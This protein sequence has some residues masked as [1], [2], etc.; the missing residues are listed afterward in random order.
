MKELILHVGRSK[1]ASSTVQKFLSENPVIRQGN[2]A[3]SYYCVTR[4]GDY[5]SG[6]ALKFAS[7]RSPHGYAVSDI[8]FADPS[9]FFHGLRKIKDQSS[10]DKV[11][12]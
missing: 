4:Q 11:A 3:L 10:A 6:D 7:K 1:C 2:L 12:W 5:I 8:D 9:S